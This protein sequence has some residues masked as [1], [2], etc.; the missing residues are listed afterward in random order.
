MSETATLERRLANYRAALAERPRTSAAPPRRSSVVAATL[1]A[2][3]VGGEVV[4]ASD[5][6]YVRVEAA[7]H[8]VAIDRDRLAR[9][10]GM[11]PAAVPLVCLDTETTG[12]STGAGTL[13]F[14]VG[15]GWWGDGR[16]RQVQY[17][18]PDEAD[19]GALLDAIHRQIP[20]DAWLVTY[21]GRSFDWPLLVA[22]YRQGGRAAPPH[23]GHLDLLP[24]VR[25]L[26]RHRMENARLKTV[27]TALL[28]IHR[29][30]DVEGWEIPG[31]YLGFLRGG[32]A[33]PLVQIVEHNDEDVR[34]LARVL[35]LLETA[36][37]D[38]A[39]RATAPSG[40]L[41]GLARSFAEQGRLV[42]ALECLETAVSRDI[43]VRPR[44][45]LR[46]DDHG[47]RVE[48]PGGGGPDR[49]RIE[50]A[51]ARLLRRL[52]RHQEAAA[53]WFAIAERGG[54][55]SVRSHIEIAKIREHVDRDHHAALRAAIRADRLLSSAWHGLHS[56]ALR[57]DLDRRL[58]RLRRRTERAAAA[59]RDR[60][61]QGVPAPR[62]EHQ[63]A[64]R[65]RP[66][67]SASWA[68]R[69]T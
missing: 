46:W 18:L 66:G 3:A 19:E 41:A 9:L 58:R 45:I 28:G 55:L 52:G 14:L 54:S 36:Y 63:P 29:H 50:S 17:L 24:V 26:F 16:F 37:A 2:D 62:A 47:V 57:R 48:R 44:V 6:S 51:H 64:E 34:S 30:E 25:R 12:L 4:T 59:T 20:A 39:V 68:T 21:N 69:S 27:E 1:L 5:G 10:P 67:R 65:G 22:R 43:V 33:A 60:G 53:V 7:G 56:D 31:R 42:E 8:D 11:P 13:A 61:R 23:A 15:L 49:D 32:P 35:A 38:P 40:D